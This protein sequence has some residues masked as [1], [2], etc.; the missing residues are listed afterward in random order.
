M[1]EDSVK[2]DGALTIYIISDSLG[3]TAAAMASAAA[4]QFEEERVV[5]ERLPRI[6][7]AAQ[8]S[9]YLEARG[10]TNA[11]RVA[12]L[13]I[14]A[15]DVRNES[16]QALENEGIP[17]VDLLGPAIDAISEATGVQ[18]VLKAGTNRQL[19]AAYF[20]RIEAMDY[21]V[22]HDDG[23]L[24]EEYKDADIILMGVSRTSK[25]PLSMY[26][27]SSGYKVANLPLALGVEPP[28]QIYDVDNWRVFGLM[29]SPRVL[30]DI[31]S[32]RLGDV[33]D[34]ILENYASEE[35]VVRDLEAA[36]AF[37]RKIGCIVVR[38]DNRA[39]EETA[40]EILM[41]YEMALAAQKSRQS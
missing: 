20:R 28:K 27:A 17:T 7:S 8:V 24:P 30:S 1:S 32:R 33:D 37:M 3:D 10:E 34:R 38:T 26:L 29:S 18:P 22:D 5:I 31:R 2:K 19:D 9:D 15:P 36:R 40:R 23:R 12:F 39:V 14:A 41:Y 25:T 13:T 21:S 4:C 6:S 35:Y 11:V 16:A